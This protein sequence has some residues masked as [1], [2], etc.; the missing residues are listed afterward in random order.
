MSTSDGGGH[1]DDAGP[2]IGR[3]Q[4]CDQRVA[5]DR[6]DGH[7]SRNHLDPDDLAALALDPAIDD[8]RKDEHLVHCAR[9]RKELETL[10]DVTARARR[11]GRSEPLPYPPDGVWDNVVRELTESGDVGLQPVRSASRWQP[12]ALAA[13]L[14]FAAVLAAAALLP[15]TGSEVVATATLEALADVEP[16][17]AELST[18]DEGRTLTIDEIDLPETDGYY[19]L[20]LLTPEGDGLISLGPVGPQATVEIPPAIDTDRFSVVDISR[21]PQD[22][23]PAHSTDSVLRGALEP[24]V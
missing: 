13:A 16:A 23:D 12:W 11:S 9:C 8:L 3:D 22:G 10:R 1:S 4:V 6:G 17:R 21:E 14:V 24:E 20:W 2:D 15:L 18:E 5:D 19:E 7:P